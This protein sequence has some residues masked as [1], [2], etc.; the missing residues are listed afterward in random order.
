MIT[1]WTATEDGRRRRK[2][3]NERAWKGRNRLVLGLINHDTLSLTVAVL[4]SRISRGDT[5]GSKGTKSCASLPIAAERALNEPARR[6]LADL[7]SR[8]LALAG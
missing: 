2:G 6:H 4:L 3:G 5:S 1:E 8:L 7:A